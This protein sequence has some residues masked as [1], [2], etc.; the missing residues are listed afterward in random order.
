M[1]KRLLAS[2]RSG[3]SWRT[4]ASDLD[5]EIA[6][7]LSEEAEERQGDG[8]PAHAAR[9]AARRDFGNV[10]L[11]REDVR[12]AWG[13]G[14]MERAL[15]DVRYGLRAL[16][17]APVVTTV[18]VLTLTLA[19]GANTA[20]FS[21][22]NGLLLRPLPVTA[23]DRLALLAV[24]IDST[25][26]RTHWTNPIWEQVRDQPMFDGAF[27]W[28]MQRFNL[29]PTGES[30]VVSGLWVSGRMFEVLGVDTVVGRP[31]TAGDDRRTLGSDGPVAVLGYDFWQRR[32]GGS[33]DA[34]GRRITVE[35]VP[36]TIVGVAPPSFFGAEVGRTFDVA[37]PIAA[38]TVVKGPGALDRR[39]SWWLRIM[40]LLK[41]GQTPAAAN[42]QL[43]TLTPGIR[44]ATQPADV[45]PGRYLREGLAVVA[46]PNGP[47][48]LRRVYERP[49]AVLMG[50]VFVVLL[51]ACANLAN[52]LLARAAARQPELSLRIALGASRGRIARQ[53]LLESLM[54]AL[55]GAVGGLILARFTSQALVHALSTANTTARLDMG[56]DWRSLGFTAAVG[57]LTA[58]FFGVAPALRG[59]RAQPSDALK[60][61]GRSGAV[62]N[63]RLGQALVVAQVALSLVLLVAAGLFVRTFTRLMH[64]DLGFDA[65]PVLT[66]QIVPGA[67]LVRQK[68]GPWSARIV[69][70]AAGVPG[71]RDAALSYTVPMSGNNWNNLVGL[72]AGPPRPDA[73]LTW[74][75]LVTPGWFATYDTRLLDGR[76]FTAADDAGAAPVAI[77][78]QAFARAFNGGRSPVGVEIRA[79]RRQ[80][81]RRPSRRRLG[82]GCGVRIGAR[83]GPSD[84][85]PAVCAGRRRAGRQHAERPR[86]RRPA[87]RRR[88]PAGRGAR[89]RRSRVERDLPP[90]RRPSRRSA[91]PRAPPGDPRRR[92]RRPRR[93]PRR[94]GTLRRHGLRREPAARR[95]RHP[96]G[97]RR[98]GRPGRRPHPRRR[99]GPRGGRRRDRRRADGVG[100]TGRR[101]AALRADAARLGDHRRRHGTPGDD[102][103]SRRLDPGP[104]RLPHRSGS[105]PS[106]RIV[107]LRWSCTVHGARVHGSCAGARFVHGARVRRSSEHV[108]T[109]RRAQPS[110]TRALCTRAPLR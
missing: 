33:P 52:L 66:A 83:A 18:A 16:A 59:T 29:A 21:L 28:G 72:A 99:R 32:F 5:D 78:N 42:A 34:I 43:A 101:D 69:A 58:L 12:E 98:V 38:A 107:G 71:V 36:F 91:R 24:P 103:R 20:I 4:R 82:G 44:Q 94:R 6:F 62:T 19:I 17:A 104:P 47:S 50:V 37:I 79:R 56:L 81:A 77:V 89:A 22:I 86:R 109:R 14:P 87:R 95:D 1:L 31:I 88:A 9:D 100:R 41:P 106:G 25:S 49:L 26:E 60:Q 51:I 108:C 46:A 2:V 30:D 65:V 74:F 45:P 84:A 23:P 53:L 90:A 73:P 75:N 67:D 92:L 48:A 76:D 13:W 7:H 96:H 63:G 55:P 97:A 40:F 3:R 8:L 10:G 11:V 102:R 35:R 27:A 57:T 85:V 61:Q 80:G 110:C 105:G 93:D 70:A 64:R 15:Q 39:A 54:I 68:A